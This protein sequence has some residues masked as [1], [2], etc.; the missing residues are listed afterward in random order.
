MDRSKLE[1]L[2]AQVRTGGK[3]SVRRKWKA[4]H[5]TAAADDK[6]LQATLQ[7]L[8]GYNTIS[9]IEEVNLF[10]DDGTV[11][12]FTTPKVNA[13]VEANTF[14]ITGKAETKQLQELLPGILNQLGLDNLVHLKKLAE[15]GAK[16]GQEHAGHD[17]AGH[18]HAA[19]EHKEKK[20]EKKPE[21]APATAPATQKMP[22]PAP[23]PAPAPAGQK[24]KKKAPAKKEAAPAPAPAPAA[25]KK[26]EA[27]P[28]PA[29]AAEKKA[30]AAPAPAPAPAA[31]KKA[32]AA[33]ATPAAEKPAEKTAQ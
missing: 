1:K 23:A 3:G 31:E 22:H 17:H 4:P 20:A 8:P 7:R 28:A 9:G 5:K 30:E 12:H 29:P 2:A 18:D 25:E 24:K 16:K 6:R 15:E 10:K 13:S 21:A 14:V 11:I 27:A 32:E 33:P 26:A 19:H